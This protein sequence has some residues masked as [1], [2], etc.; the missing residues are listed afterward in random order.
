MNKAPALRRPSPRQH[1]ALGAALFRGQAAIEAW[2]VLQQYSN[3]LDQT[4]RS[5][6]RLLPMTYR[7]L[8]DAGLPESEL[9]TL[10]GIYRQAWYRNRVVIA[11]AHR[12][13][14]ALRAA[15]IEP[16]A[17]K[18]LGLVGS[19]YD[20]VALRPMDDIDLLIRPGQHTAASEALMR[21]GW[22]PTR[23]TVKRYFRRAR[24]FHGM[25]L[26]AAEDIE[27]D[28]HSAMLEEHI[29]PGIDAS[30]YERSVET[31]LDGVTVRTLSLE[32]HLLNACVHGAR[33]DWGLPL[34]WI[35]DVS[36]IA[37]RQGALDW[38]YILAESRRRGVVLPVAAGLALVSEY[39]E[40]IPPEVVA[41]A[42][43]SQASRFERWNF[44][45]QQAPDSLYAN[46]VRTL[47]RYLQ[48]AA[49]RPIHTQIRDFPVYLEWIWELE[50]PRQ[51]PADAFRRVKARIR[52]AR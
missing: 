31:V 15:G 29:S 49:R 47:G 45:A 52:P 12:T 21:A 37:R 41:T 35:V 34:R 1:A 7:N 24:V 18:G 23:G 5:T 13:L 25:P 51:L 44:G 11:Y 16:L 17:L 14:A 43:S 27:V 8:R 42:A 48:M 26:V 19:A 6:F 3:H 33:W 36:T 20:G 39:C 28:L 4:D 22:K 50:S 30:L 40:A 9:L 10:K 46:T 38:D 2:R 32:D